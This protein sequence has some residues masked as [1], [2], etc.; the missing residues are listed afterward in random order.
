[1]EQTEKK[2]QIQNFTEFYDRLIKKL[3]E[4]VDPREIEKIKN[5]KTNNTFRNFLGVQAEQRRI[6][7]IKKDP[8]GNEQS[9]SGKKYQGVVQWYTPPKPGRRKIGFESLLFVA[10]GNTLVPVPD[11]YVRHDNNQIYNIELKEITKSDFI[12]HIKSISEKISHYLIS[13]FYVHYLQYELQSVLADEELRESYREITELLD[14]TSGRLTEIDTYIFFKTETNLDFGSLANEWKQFINSEEFCRIIA[15]ESVRASIDKY[16][17]IKD[18]A[19]LLNFLSDIKE[20]LK[21]HIREGRKK[22]DTEEESFKIAGAYDYLTDIYPQKVISG[23]R[24]AAYI[25]LSFVDEALNPDNYLSKEREVQYYLFGDIYDDLQIIMRNYFVK[26]FK[27]I[28]TKY[29]FFNRILEEEFKKVNIKISG[30]PSKEAKILFLTILAKP[31]QKIVASKNEH[32]FEQRKKAFIEEHKRLLGDGWLQIERVITR[33]LDKVENILFEKQKVSEEELI[34]VFNNVLEDYRADWKERQNELKNELIERFYS[35]V[36]LAKQKEKLTVRELTYQLTRF[37][38]RFRQSITE[39]YKV[40][41]AE[42]Q[43]DIENFILKHQRKIIDILKIS[44]LVDEVRDEIENSNLSEGDKNDLKFILDNVKNLSIIDK[45]VNIIKN[46]GEKRDEITRYLENTLPSRILKLPRKIV[47]RNN[48]TIMKEEM[49]WFDV[50]IREHINAVLTALR[51]YFT[52]VA[53]KK[54]RKNITK[55]GDPAADFHLLM[56]SLEAVIPKSKHQYLARLESEFRDIWKR[57]VK[58]DTISKKDFGE[59]YLKILQAVKK[60]MVTLSNLEELKNIKDPEEGNLYRKLEEIAYMYLQHLLI[61]RK[62]REMEKIDPEIFTEIPNR[63]V[64]NK[65]FFE[66]YDP[67]T[68]KIIGDITQDILSEL[69]ELKEVLDNKKIADEEKRIRSK[70]VLNVLK[71]KLSNLG[72]L[73]K[74]LRGEEIKIDEILKRLNEYE[75]RLETQIHHFVS[76]SF[77]LNPGLKWDNVDWQKIQQVPEIKNRIATQ[78]IFEFQKS[79]QEN[80]EDLFK[81]GKMKNEILDAIIRAYKSFND[82]DIGIPPSEEFEN[83]VSNIEYNLKEGLLKLIT[84]DSKFAEQAQRH[85][86]SI[87][88]LFAEDFVKKAKESNIPE[89]EAIARTEKITQIFLNILKDYDKKDSWIY[90]AIQDQI[91]VYLKN[92]Y[93]TICSGLIQEAKVKVERQETKRSIAFLRRDVEDLIRMFSE[94]EKSLK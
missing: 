56:E 64:V 72:E 51:A 46:P 70:I 65:D 4:L 67:D 8:Q 7:F 62:L 43:K 75:R 87:A 92:F 59:E 73:S 85:F 22:L 78:G 1:M 20:N 32:E 88:E 55:I 50:G 79:V 34:S 49:S 2:T 24:E 40:E 23:P 91:P 84:S 21:K 76:S 86:E 61:S 31:I 77:T 69:K 80:I 90:T 53:H 25:I 48:K 29:Q 42:F 71:N 3:T 93:L 74:L 27:D 47:F 13:Y 68:K 14:K 41:I 89:K 60:Y 82:P 30:L 15:Y 38:S 58:A 57:L 18:Q 16:N 83:L 52:A 54:I 10:K 9:L 63:I 28:L 19:S 6:G 44:D 35:L 17:Y 45:A 11:K 81:K 36:K 94:Y 66:Y 12:E 26:N 33:V 37:W 39:K 5:L